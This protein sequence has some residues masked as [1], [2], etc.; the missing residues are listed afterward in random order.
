MI[1]GKL[2]DFGV[3]T[4][5]VPRIASPWDHETPQGTPPNYHTVKEFD[6]RLQRRR[7]FTNSTFQWVVTIFLCGAMAG[8]LAGFE[9]IDGLSTGQKHAFNALITGLSIAVG[10]NLAS[11]LRGYAQMMRW[12]FM[13]SA[14][15]S[16]QEFELV[17]Q[18]ESQMKVLRLFW[19]ARTRGRF[20][21][22]GTQVL[23]ATWIFVNALLQVL[24]A[25]LGLT[26]NIDTSNTWVRTTYGNV[27]IADLSLIRDKYNDSIPG[28]YQ[29]LN[30]AQTYGIQG[31]DYGFY[32]DVDPADQTFQNGV[33]S[34]DNED[35]FLYRFI[36]VNPDDTSINVVSQRTINS[37]ATCDAFKVIAGGDLN[38]TNITYI[39]GAGDPVSMWIQPTSPGAMTYIGNTQSDC[40][41][42]CTEVMALQLADNIT[43][44]DTSF[45]KC[46]NT[47]GPVLD[48]TTG[49]EVVASKPYEMPDVQAQIMAGAIGWT[50]FYYTDGDP[51]EYQRYSE[52]TPWSPYDPV[53]APTT[54]LLISQFS[55]Y[56]IA[57]MDDHGP[58]IN[59][60][61]SDPV[62]AQVVSVEWKWSIIIL[63][64]IPFLQ[65]LAL[66]SIIAW[67]NKAIIK[68]DSYLGTAR[69]LRPVVNKVGPHGCMLTGDQIAEELHNVRISYGYRSPPGF[70]EGSDMVRHV[71][72]LAE[73]EGLGLQ[74]SMPQGR[75]DGDIVH[76]T[77]K[78]RRRRLSI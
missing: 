66:I 19:T 42:R 9:T 36:D 62:Q 59:V 78:R 20:W 38:S 52:D 63:A 27:S 74:R 40:G 30:A 1:G 48:A 11:S 31:E 6:Y 25:L 13:A 34:D 29:Q 65:F 64:V 77:V 45:F 26:Y 35:Y 49:Y 22:N 41:P 10:I 55:I 75:Y 57:A 16:L 33:Y 68:D 54:A 12:R 53:D 58:R 46:N 69:L 50:G 18:C 37:T 44:M 28:Y 67:A 8:T 21:L 14:Y 47:L 73:H 70:V 23:C 32:I 76:D 17:M 61:G 24:V 56:A 3:S 43:I 7:L 72:I 39:D 15:R 2:R 60:T 4:F 71:D 51:L 5:T